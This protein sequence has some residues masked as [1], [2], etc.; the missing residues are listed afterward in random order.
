MVLRKNMKTNII[1]VISILG[2]LIAP[3]VLSQGVFKENQIINPS[4]SPT[5]T[6]KPYTGT[7]RVYIVEIESRWRMENRQPYHYAF[8]DYAYYDELS[9]PYLE[10]FEENMNWQGDVTYNNVI[11]LAAVFNSNSEQRYADPPLGRPFD[12]YFVDAAAGAH[13]DETNENVNDGGFTHTVFCEVGTATWCPSCPL[14]A[15]VLEDV[16]ESDKYPFFFVEMVTDESSIANNR[17]GDYN[18]KW[19]PT[20]F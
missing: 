12:A 17:M 19:L 20:A 18:L 10:T 5:V 8:L 2:M 1:I 16:Y 14:M 6:A 4:I 3:T 11:V 7:L 15:N 9:I 13:P